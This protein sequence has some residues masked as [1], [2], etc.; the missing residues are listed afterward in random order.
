MSDLAALRNP[1]DPLHSNYE[2]PKELFERF[3]KASNGFPHEFV[4]DAA[5]NVLINSVR[6]ANSRRSGALKGFDEA[7]TKARAM[8]AEHYDGADNRRNIFPFHQVVEMAHFKNE[9]K[10]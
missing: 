4:L 1:K 6:Q 7:V 10:F 2:G 9:Q 3:A 8:L 5:L